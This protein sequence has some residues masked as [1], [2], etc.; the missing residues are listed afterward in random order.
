MECNELMA[1][2]VRSFCIGEAKLTNDVRALMACFSK[3]Q[4]P[5]QWRAE[6]VVDKNVSV[7]AWVADLAAR[8]AELH[9][10]VDAL[11]KGLGPG[12]SSSFW[13]GGMF[14]PEAFVTATRQQTAQVRWVLHFAVY[15]NN[16]LLCYF[17][18]GEQV[19]SGGLGALPRHRGRGRRRGVPARPLCRR[20]FDRGGTDAGGGASRGR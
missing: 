3:G 18:L 2:F 4:L 10:Y 19:E 7:N 8:C 15:V 9:K 12:A 6:Y 1:Y 20:G 16:L 14:A 5:A 13:I 17:I 11:K